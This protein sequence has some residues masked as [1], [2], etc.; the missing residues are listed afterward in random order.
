MT[1][2]GRQQKMRQQ[3]QPTKDITHTVA[4]S[5]PGKDITHHPCVG[6]VDQPVL[7]GMQH[8]TVLLTQLPE[9]GREEDAQLAGAHVVTVLQ[10]H[11]VHIHHRPQL[12]AVLLL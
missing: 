9:G 5:Q 8:L 3:T 4:V 7:Q 10:G 1:T 6:P 12:C 11:L 2:K